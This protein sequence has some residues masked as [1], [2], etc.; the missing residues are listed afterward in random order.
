MHVPVEKLDTPQLP[1][2]LQTSLCYQALHI[3]GSDAEEGGQHLPGLHASTRQ[4]VDELPALLAEVSR[5]V[6]SREGGG[7]QHDAR[8]AAGRRIADCLLADVRGVEDL[9]CSEPA[10]L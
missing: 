10:W 1:R 6:A 2:V 5:A 7:V 3:E 9:S 4:P 8:G